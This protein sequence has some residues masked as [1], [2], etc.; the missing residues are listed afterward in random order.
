[1]NNKITTFP[2]EL[3]WQEKKQ[4]FEL[5]NDVYGTN[6]ME[7]TMFFFKETKKYDKIYCSH[8]TIEQYAFVV[9][10]NLTN[11]MN[12]LE[13]GRF[14][15]NELYNTITNKLKL[16]LTQTHFQDNIFRQPKSRT[17]D[18]EFY[19]LTQNEFELIP[20]NC[21]PITSAR[22]SIFSI[23]LNDS[24]KVDNELKKYI[25]KKLSFVKTNEEKNYMMKYRPMIKAEIN[26]YVPNTINPEA[27]EIA[28]K[29]NLSF[30]EFNF[31]NYFY[32][33]GKSLRN[34]CGQI[35][36][37]VKQ[38]GLGWNDDRKWVKSKLM[39]L[40]ELGLVKFEIR[41]DCRDPRFSS[42]YFYDANK[43]LDDLKH[44]L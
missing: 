9:K 18:G 7:Y 8:D 12:S 24:V 38:K 42:W 32:E 17:I 43:K 29:Y 39:K 15:K 40:I 37:D 6:D 27:F 13:F 3:G 23:T 16:K 5:F 26:R 4:G 19:V 25:Q 44:D 34:G 20:F 35:Y 2:A 41:Y 31:L 36:F 28:T 21:E 30:I 33:T 22:E 1:M 11:M 10:D 14:N